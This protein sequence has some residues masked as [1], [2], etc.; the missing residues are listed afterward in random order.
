VTIVQRIRD[1]FFIIVVIINS[2]YWPHIA[3]IWFGLRTVRLIFL[4]HVKIFVSHVNIMILETLSLIYDFLR[5]LKHRWI[6]IWL[7]VER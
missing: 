1:L 2:Q 3:S 5:V 6:G 4:R 7:L